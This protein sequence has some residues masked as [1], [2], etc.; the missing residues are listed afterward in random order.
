M[1]QAK[2]KAEKKGDGSREVKAKYMLFGGKLGKGDVFAVY[3]D[4]EVNVVVSPQKKP[5]LNI[6][7]YFLP[8]YVD[9]QLTHLKFGFESD[10][11]GDKI[12]SYSGELTRENSTAVYSSKFHSELEVV[13]GTLIYTSFCKLGE[14]TGGDCFKTRNMVVETFYD[15]VNTNTFGNK[16]SLYIK[17]EKVSFLKLES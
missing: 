6:H 13:E 14:A 8:T 1:I 17:N 3:K 5:K 9:D 7:Q 11:A 16:L 10:R 4:G 12:A 15:K 2:V